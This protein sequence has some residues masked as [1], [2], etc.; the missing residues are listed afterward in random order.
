M[1]NLK[2]NRYVILEII[3][4]KISN[5]DIA[6]IS[7]LKINKLKLEDT[8]DYR[9]DKDKIDVADILKITNY[10]NDKFK[11]VKT[12]NEIK[13][14]FKE[15][16]GNLPLL[17]IDNLY[18]NNYLECFKNDKYSI[19]DYLNLSVS[20]MVFDELIKK[21]NLVPSNHL[22]DLLYEA[23]IMEYN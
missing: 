13:R 4:T 8:F 6:Q 14:K 9:L 23:L 22:V 20:D 5:G 10:D 21:Y 17:I 15:F 2:N 16:I 3:P 18:T 7:A 19:F 1:K 11:Y 12:T